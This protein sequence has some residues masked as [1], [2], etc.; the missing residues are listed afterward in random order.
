MNSPQ[1]LGEKLRKRR[2]E[3]NFT[4]RDLA[5]K[6]DL[7]AAF[8]SQL[9]NNKSEPSL[10]SLQRIA[11]A[12]CIP[13]MYFL[14]EAPAQSPVVRAQNRSLLEFDD[15]R[16]RYQLLTPDINRKM[17]AFIGE[18]KEA[19]GENIARRLP[20]ETEEW[21]FVLE[22][23]LKVGLG[24]TYYDLYAG[25]AIYFNGSQLTH[26]SNNCQGTVRWISVITPPVF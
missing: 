18:I 13:I 5:K 16:V 11:D 26:I 3:L 7:T 8:L 4:L 1:T 23:S 2:K 19:C 9:E 12:L 17:E 10:K 14:S 15:H 6:T 20:V 25:D 21:I 24:A 22:G